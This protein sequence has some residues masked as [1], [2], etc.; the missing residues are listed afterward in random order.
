MGSWIF[1]L[2]KVGLME[3]LSINLIFLGF[4]Q[5]F[6]E[7]LPISSSAHLSLAATL[8]SFSAFNLVLATGLH[9]GSVVAIFYWFHRDIVLLSS[10]FF[11]SLK[12]IKKRLLKK[13]MNY[14]VIQR[15]DM[16][17][18]YYLAASLIPLAIEG[19]LL[20]DLAEKTF[21]GVLWVS[22]LM[23]LNGLL[24]LATA[25]WTQGERTLGELKLWE[26]MMIGA[27]QGFAVLPG[28]SRLGLTLCLG[29]NRRL[30]W[31]EALRLAFLYAIPVILG[32][33]LLQ[34]PDL[35]QTLF[36]NSDWVYAFIISLIVVAITSLAG[37]KI[38]TSSLLERRTLLFFGYYCFMVGV[39]TAVYFVLWH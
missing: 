22:I 11:D 6:S 17:V 9:A 24:I 20:K 4:V 5:G 10:N 12:W 39:F 27:I 2:S 30:N 34:T 25:R 35:I 33:T 8:L 7:V 26:Y 21:E 31:R 36:N 38:L 1:I 16:R 15:N 23:I 3:H 14:S 13:Q 18:P 29:L 32:A 28:I 19:Y 37:L